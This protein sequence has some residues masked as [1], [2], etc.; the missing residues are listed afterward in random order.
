M[1]KN[2]VKIFWGPKPSINKNIGPH[3]NASS[4]YKKVHSKLGS[5]KIDWKQQ[6]RLYVVMDNLGKVNSFQVSRFGMETPGF[7]DSF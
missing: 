1:N 2:K 6:K 5:L 3:Q 7:W 4:S